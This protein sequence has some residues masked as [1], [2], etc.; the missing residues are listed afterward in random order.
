MDVPAEPS[1]HAEHPN[2]DRHATFDL[3]D[4]PS[5]VPPEE[6]TDKNKPYKGETKVHFSG[7]LDDQKSGLKRGST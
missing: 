5:R 3:A 6:G 2:I 4:S 1:E 7:N